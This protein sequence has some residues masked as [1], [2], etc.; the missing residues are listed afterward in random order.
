M[1]MMPLYVKSDQRGSRRSLLALVW[2][3]KLEEVDTL[4][5]SGEST[6]LE[7]LPVD[8]IV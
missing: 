1:N 8:V 3:L 2:Q 6:Y 5:G 7:D 4:L